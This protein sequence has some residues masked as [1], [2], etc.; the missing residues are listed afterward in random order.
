M[1]RANSA[2]VSTRR[3]ANSNHNNLR[4]ERELLP[5]VRPVYFDLEPEAEV[6]LRVLRNA[7]AIETFV[8]VTDVQSDLQ[9][10]LLARCAECRSLLIASVTA[11]RIPVGK[12]RPKYIRLAQLLNQFS[13]SIGSYAGMS[14]SVLMGGEELRS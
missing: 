5:P 11:P 9:K 6:F 10:Q 1:A 4:A 12:L 2:R 8:R 7:T 3:K 14:A 13:I